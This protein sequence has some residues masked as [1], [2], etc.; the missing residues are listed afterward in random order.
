MKILIADDNI[1][2]AKAISTVLE[3][4]KQLETMDIKF[5]HDLISTKRELRANYY[6]LL[7]LDIQ[8]PLRID[9]QAEDTGGIDLLNE[10]CSN[11]KYI[12]PGNIIG[13]TEH[14]RCFELY[15]EKFLSIIKYDNSTYNWECELESSIN[16]IKMITQNR[17]RPSI[18]IDNY[19]V[20]II[21]ALETPELSAIKE[22][23]ASW[24][25]IDIPGDNTIY[26]ST[27]FT[28]IN[29]DIKV[30]AAA[31]E[32]MGMT[33]AAVL[34]MK[35]INNF[36]PL[37]LIMPGISGGLEGEVNL[38]DVIIA[39]PSWDY[40]SGKIKYENGEEVF[41]PDP[42]QLRVDKDILNRIKLICAN[43]ELLKTIRKNW[44]GNRPTTEINVCI[45]P[46]ATGAAVVAN[47]KT[48]DVIKQSKRKVLGIE[49][50]IFGV[51]YAAMNC[52]KP[53]P[54]VFGLKSVCDFADPYKSDG[55]QDYAAYVSARVLYK[56][57]ELYL[58]F[59]IE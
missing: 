12:I 13:I 59:D 43:K 41:C 42:L 20:A 23:S 55:F 32:Q 36:R 35:M 58:D 10:I 3:R 53:R 26:Y 40:G 57:I 31:C 33:A 25:I 29:K 54:Y 11:N 7:L 6:D 37:Y 46:V 48:I 4:T 56:L 15:K 39:D 28:T 2:K 34:S 16:Y 19:D 1:N 9:R 8:M 49:M 27:T 21:C 17:N 51:M 44:D 14:E 5:V 50:E 52:S 45:G 18:V 47:K 24:D 30:I 22:L 38:G